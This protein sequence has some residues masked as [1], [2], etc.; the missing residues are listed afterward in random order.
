MKAA[1]IGTGFLGQQIY[2]D[3]KDHCD[4]VIMT[5]NRNQKYP[6]SQKF[7]FFQDDISAI[8]GNEKIDII[9]LPAKIEFN[10]NED[11]LKEAMGKFLD[12]A[13]DSRIVY[14]SSDGIFD[15]QHGSYKENDVTEPMTLYGKNLKICEELIKKKTKNYCILRPSYLYGYVD[16]KLDSRFEKIKQE[17]VENKKIVRFTDMYKSPL[18][19]EQAAQAIVELALSDYVGTVHISGKRMSVYEFTRQG[20]EALDLSTE[21]LVGETMPKEKPIDFL[22]DTSLDNTLMRKLTSI[23]PIDIKE[24]FKNSEMHSVDNNLLPSKYLR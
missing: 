6:N 14:V 22:S 18:N 11:L 23:E 5:H 20:M 21:N 3:I 1:I 12:A 13:K 9:F 16:G 15:G 19:Y 7:D 10:E 8:L 24:G 17:L 2:N 4:E